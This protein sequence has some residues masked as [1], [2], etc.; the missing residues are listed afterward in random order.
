MA[1]IAHITHRHRICS[2]VLVL[3]LI[4]LLSFGVGADTAQKRRIL[5]GLKL[6]PAVIAANEHLLEEEPKP[7]KLLIIYHDDADYAKELAETLRRVEHIKGRELKVDVMSFAKLLNGS[8]TPPDALF[9]SERLVDD[10]P[11]V[12]AYGIQHG[13]ITFSPFNGDVELGILAGISI[14]DRILPYINNGTLRRTQ[15]SLKPFFLK[16]AEIYEP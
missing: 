11:A 14:S 8:S 7:L 2:R 15:L 3:F 13:V 4:G 6:F 10:I 5:V 9:L 16:V 12:A 1:W